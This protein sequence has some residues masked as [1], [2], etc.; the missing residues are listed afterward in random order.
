MFASPGAA[1]EGWAVAL[2][3]PKTRAALR[4]FQSRRLRRL[5]HHAYDRVPYYR[6]LF[7]SAGLT[8][9][10]IRGLEDLQKIPLTSRDDVQFLPPDQICARGSDP[11]SLLVRRTSGSSGAPLTVRRRRVEERLLQA[12][13][14]SYIRDYGG[15]CRSRRAEI[16]YVAGKADWNAVPKKPPIYQRLGFYRRLVLDWDI[17]KDEMI[18]RLGK[19]RTEILVG[20]PSALSWKADE[21]TDADR[22]RLDIRYLVTGGET[23]T[24]DVRVR[25]E[26]GWGAPIHDT[27]GSHEFVFIAN[28]QPGGEGYRVCSESLIVEVLRDGKPAAPGEEGELVGTALHSFAMPFVRYRLGDLVQLGENE[29]Q[30]DS[31][32]SRLLRING[33]TVERFFLSGERVVHPYAIANILRDEE[34]WL[35]RF[36]IMQPE[37]DRLHIR[38]VPLDTPGPDRLQQAAR[39]IEGELDGSVSVT[40]QLVNELPPTAGGK[41]QPYL[42]YEQLLRAKPR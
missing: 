24:A 14:L 15:S 2:R 10:D 28:Q 42:S 25:L 21:L 33:R 1:V 9:E 13:R 29:D 23:L 22:E 16:T 4:A 20:A 34:P 36:Q 7:D 11:K 32:V 5:V 18:S 12:L 6:R 8:P 37:R 30:A 26:R 35:R 41:F 38:I 39:R 3:R 17:P 31:S 19:S 27:Y 40:L